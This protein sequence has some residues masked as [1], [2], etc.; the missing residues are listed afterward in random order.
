MPHELLSSWKKHPGADIFSLGLT[1]YE[2]AAS[3]SFVLPSEGPRWHAIRKGAQS[4]DIPD[5]RS[6][7]LVSTIK[8]MINPNPSKRPKA[9]DILFGVP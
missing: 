2:L 5:R 6:H 3:C 4:L 7:N 9:L 1:L 8:S